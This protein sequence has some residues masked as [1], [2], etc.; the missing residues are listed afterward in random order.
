MLN[1]KYK[2]FYDLTRSLCPDDSFYRFV[3][4][5]GWRDW[6]GDIEPGHLVELLVYAWS[7][8][9][10]PISTIK[11]L[12]GL[13]LVNLSAQFGVPKINLDSWI[14]GTRECP[15]YVWQ[16]FAYCVLDNLPCSVSIPAPSDDDPQDSILAPI[17]VK[18]RE[19]AR[20]SRMSYPDFLRVVESIPDCPT[21]DSFVHERGWQDW[22]DCYPDDRIIAVLDVIWSLR[23]NPVRGAKAAAHRTTAE[24]AADYGIPPGSITAW[25]SPR[26]TRFSARHWML[27]YCILADEG[28]I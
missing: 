14:A 4:E 17:I 23:D 8:R 7:L 19:Q 16:M 6:M 22:M 13:T 5:C 9:K 11:E 15:D 24:L 27:A 26:A 2:H 1:I 21:L 3:R 10:S 20:R 25:S 12:S 28:L 18:A